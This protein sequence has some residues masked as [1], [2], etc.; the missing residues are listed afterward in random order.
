MSPL[1]RVL[2]HLLGGTRGGPTRIRIL[3]LLRDRPQNTNQVSVML[4]IDYKT[5]EH[6]L[7]V[8]RENRLVVP[9][10]EGYGTVFL[11]SPALEAEIREFD[12]IASKVLGSTPGGKATS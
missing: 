7:K 3:A 8:L 11:L 10:G 2:W 5:A 4:G 9:S 6:H 1:T 12:A